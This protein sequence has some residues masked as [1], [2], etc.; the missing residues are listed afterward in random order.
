MRDQPRSEDKAAAPDRRL[1]PGWPATPAEAWRVQE[2]LASRV[3]TRDTFGPVRWIAG[4]DVHYLP[5]R[6]LAMAA[7][8]LLE[9]E[10]QELVTSAL[11][12]APLA[13][14]YVPGLLSF[15]EAPAAL[16][17]LALLEPRPDLLLVDGQGLA[18]PRRFGLACHIGLLT[19][20]PTIG[21][22]KSRL[23]GTFAPPAPSAGSWTPLLDGDAVIGAVLR[24]HDGGRPLFVSIGHRVSL[25]AAVAWTLRCC[26]GHRLPEPTRLADRLPRAQRPPSSRSARRPAGPGGRGGPPADSPR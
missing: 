22:A 21:V 24:T 12:A 16:A 14:P 11:A 19:D 23:V 18:H 7:A 2:V 17:A 4:V 10:S 26:R 20:L 3:I 15:R 13:F 25:E 1:P 5:R 9:A 6:R 8:V